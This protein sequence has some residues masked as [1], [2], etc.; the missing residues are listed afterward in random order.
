MQDQNAQGGVLSSSTLILV[1]FATAFF[2]RIIQSV[3]APAPINFVHFAIVPLVFG[4]VLVKTRVKNK[5]QISVVRDLVSGLTILLTIMVASALLND[6]GAI[7]VFVDLILLGE[8]FIFLVTLLCLPIT[9]ERFLFIKKWF[10][11]FFFIHLF[12]CHAQK[13][14]LTA[15]ILPHTRLTIEDNIQ[16]VF[17][18]SGGG[19]VVAASVS[20]FA[21]LYFMTN[22]KHVAV[23]IRICVLGAAI[24]QILLADAKQV[25]LVALVS[26]GILI[27]SRVKDIKKTLQ[28]IIA[29][30][31][32]IYALL[33]CMD[34]LEI[35][36]AYKTW[37][38][39]EIYGPNG[40]ATVLK[41]GPFRI[42][43][44]YYE[45]YLNWF[46]GLGPGHTIGRLGGW[47]VI[48]YRSL[49]EPL[50]STIHPATEAVWRT[51][52]NYYLDSSFFSPFWG[53]AGVWGDLGFLGLAA[54]LYL[55]SIVWRRLCVDDFSRFIVLNV[56][57][58][59][60][61]FTLLEEPGFVL[62]VAVLVALRYE[63]KILRQQLQNQPYQFVEV[64]Y[65]LR[66][67]DDLL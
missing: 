16:G 17:Y 38:R 65:P 64:N 45:S 29:I 22:E 51:W 9:L 12:L 40:D 57:V 55:W 62:T 30:T 63:E 49:L 26:W 13:I 8:C 35:F 52:R 33:W 25:L 28:Y 3:G 14:L 42:I 20:L 58:N 47:M 60:F 54:Y 24:L 56:F 5:Q 1:A 44:S 66:A 48:D 53:F 23:W 27:L 10:L 11:R 34:N 43:P 6:A 61:I 50:G 37:I 4:I 2:P 21:C 7:N 32:V 41:T 59:G 46:L 67:S 39:P 19:H 18:L 36:R 31:L 15:G